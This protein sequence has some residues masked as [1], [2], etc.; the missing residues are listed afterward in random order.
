MPLAVQG[1]DVRVP[2][3]ERLSQPAFGSAVLLRIICGSARM[4]QISRMPKVPQMHSMGWGGGKAP[5]YCGP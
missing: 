4:L 1:A 3:Q 2:D 5:T